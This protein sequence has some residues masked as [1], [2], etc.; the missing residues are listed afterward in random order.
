[1]EFYIDL[2]ESFIESDNQLKEIEK[3]TNAYQHLIKLKIATPRIMIN[4]AQF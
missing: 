4:F 1:M 3:V 2:L